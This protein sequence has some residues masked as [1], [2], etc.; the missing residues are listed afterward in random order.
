[1]KF[2]IDNPE[3]KNAQ[4]ERENRKRK[5]RLKN[6]RISI[7]SRENAMLTDEFIQGMNENMKLLDLFSGIG[8][9]HKG[10]HKPIFLGRFLHR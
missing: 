4:Q 5:R 10:L 3:F 6:K 9:F 2:I 7:A 1:M 8:G